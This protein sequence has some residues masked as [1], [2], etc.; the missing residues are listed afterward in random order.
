MALARL[1]SVLWVGGAQWAGKTT[2]ARLLGARYPLVVYAYDYHDARSH[3]RERGPTLTVFLR[4]TPSLRHWTTTPTAS[5]PDPSPEQMAEREL[6]VFSERFQMVLED[7]AALPEATAVL[8]EGWGLRP[9]LVAPH[10]AVPDH[11]IFLV[12][13][14]SFRQ[15]QLDALGRAKRL[16]I[17]GLREPA[18]AQRNRVER[19]RLLADDV[20]ASAAALGLPVLVVDGTENELTVA[21]R[22][23]KQFR[24]F[25]PTWLY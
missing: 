9:R 21:G 12:P 1:D 3:R 5:G 16:G 11:A 22:V 6:A 8:A 14:E 19:D 24:P 25:L 18:R 17:R 20:V 15:S 23:E 2:V 13:S 7:L 4:I 10:V